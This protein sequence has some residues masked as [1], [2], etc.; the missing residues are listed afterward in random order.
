MDESH[1]LTGYVYTHVHLN[2]KMLC[3]LPLILCSA[4]VYCYNQDVDTVQLTEFTEDFVPAS[5]GRVFGPKAEVRWQRLDMG[6]HAYAVSVLSESPQALDKDWK[7]FSYG[8]KQ[9]KIYLMGVWQPDVR[10]WVEARLS[11]TLNYPLFG[12]LDARARLF[13]P[14]VEYSYQGMVQYIRFKGLQ[15]EVIKEA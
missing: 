2:E 7:V 14:A 1:I 9:Q 6:A 12:L 4:P 13:A 8:T 5:E 15:V 3:E 11:H 10:A